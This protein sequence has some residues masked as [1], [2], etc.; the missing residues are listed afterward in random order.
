MSRSHLINGLLILAV[1]F[2]TIHYRYIDGL[3]RALASSSRIL[4]SYRLIVTKHEDDNIKASSLP[5]M[6]ELT[7]WRGRARIGKNW[8]TKSYPSEPV[9]TRM[10]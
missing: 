3:L 6:A 4:S 2:I 8:L 10:T 1:G 7:G 9:E 5:Y